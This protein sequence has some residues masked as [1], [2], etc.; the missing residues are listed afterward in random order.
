MVWRAIS[1]GSLRYLIL[2]GLVS[3]LSVFLILD[4]TR[5][6][7]AAAV[8]VLALL[9]VISETAA[10]KVQNLH[11]NLLSMMT[12]VSLAVFFHPTQ[13][14]TLPTTRFLAYLIPFLGILLEIFYFNQTVSQ[15]ERLA[16]QVIQQPGETSRA[17]SIRQIQAFFKEKGQGRI[18]SDDAIFYPELSQ[19]P[20]DWTWEGH[21][22]PDF[23]H[24]LQQPK[25]YADYLL[26][27]KPDQLL[28]LND[29]VAT[30]LDRLDYHGIELPRKV[31][32]EDDFA[33]ILEL[34]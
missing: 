14:K 1:E 18:L 25:L 9:Y 27:T 3:A 23:Q 16:L 15:K 28:H 33:L 29:I 8:V 22:S 26:V 31:V 17:A 10:D 19:L 20:A 12:G 32:Y 7:S 11:L 2:I 24:A 34:N 4:A 5:G 21:F 13:S 6:K 30:A